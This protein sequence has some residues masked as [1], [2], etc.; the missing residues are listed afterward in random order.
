MS[1]SKRKRTQT[2]YNEVFNY[3]S[4]SRYPEECGKDRKRVI[5]RT[6]VNFVLQDGL[7]YRVKGGKKQQW[8]D[9]KRK[10]QQIIESCHSHATAA[11]CGRDK[12]RAKVA[13]RFFLAW[14]VHGCGRIR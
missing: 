10:Q 4:S 8:V 13:E 5:R 3:L 1:F 7:L 2:T 11:H 14:C 6:A 12:T 9:D